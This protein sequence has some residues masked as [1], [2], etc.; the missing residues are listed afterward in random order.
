[1]ALQKTSYMV[2]KIILQPMMP[3]LIV[4]DLQK[5]AINFFKFLQYSTHKSIGGGIKR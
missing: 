3:V 1:M 4:I 2:I 5:H